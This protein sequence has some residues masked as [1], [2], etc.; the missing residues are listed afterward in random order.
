MI[1]GNKKGDSSQRINRRLLSY[2]TRLYAPSRRQKD[3]LFVNA[4]WEH[5]S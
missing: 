2:D 4:I 3:E 5:V 1:S